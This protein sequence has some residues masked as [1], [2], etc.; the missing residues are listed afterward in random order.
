VC[1][2]TRDL[3]AF[4]VYLRRGGCLEP[5]SCGL[6]GPQTCLRKRYMYP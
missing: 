4:V 3:R 1:A 5:L 2:T 6:A